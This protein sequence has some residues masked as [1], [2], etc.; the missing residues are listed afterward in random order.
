MISVHNIRTV[1]RYEA[2][3]LRRSW[4]FRLFSLGALFILTLM[5]IGMFSP[6]GN[7]AWQTLAIPSTLPQINLYMINIAQ[8]LIVIFLASDF[9]KRDKKLDTN[10]VLY[11]RPMSNLEYITGKTLGILR[12]FLGVNLLVLLICLIINII[13][14]QASIDIAAYFEYI[15][16]ISIPT[17]IFSLG[18][19]YI[20]MTLIK[21][22]AV[23]FLL[24]LGLA[25]LNM[26]YLFNR[27]NSFFDYMLFGF[28]VFKSTISGFSEPGIIVS[29]RIMY[30]S[31][32]LLFISLTILMFKRLPQSVSH[33]LISIT[34]VIVFAVISAF[35]AFYFLN[36]YFSDEKLKHEVIETNRLYQ[37]SNFLETTSADIEIEYMNKEIKAIANLSC[38]NNTGKEVEQILFSLNSGLKISN[39]DI[40]GTGTYNTDGHIITINP[41]SPLAP[42]SSIN[43]SFKY[44]GSIEEAFCYPWYTDDIKENS[45]SIGP[46]RVDRKHVIQRDEYLLL[47]PETHWYPVSGLNYYPDNPA[48]IDVDFTNYSLKVKRN[49]K[50]VAVSQGER[51]SDED[52]WY[53]MNNSPL[54]GLSLAQGKYSSDTITV[55]SIDFIAHYYEGHDYFRD[56][57]KEL[58][59][60]IGH[61]ISGIIT[62]LETN[63]NAE[64]PFGSLSLVEVPVHFNSV[65]KKNTQ[66]RAEVQ[67]SM[68]FVPEKLATMN[69]AG[70]YRTIKRQKKRME[71]SN[72]V[73][74][75]KEIQVRAFNNFVRNTFITSS[76][77]RFNRGG[78]RTQVR[79]RYLLGPSFYFYK[80]NFYSE[81]YPVINAVF[82]THLQKTETPQSGFQRMFLGGMTENDKANTIL[83]EHSM[84]DILAMNPSNDTT[85]IILSLKGDYL[86][87]LMRAE[88]GI[89]E[90]NGWFY[91]YLEQNQFSNIDINKFSRD[92][93]ERFGFDL[94]A[95]IDNWY[96]GVGQPGFLFTDISVN[97]VVV[98]NRTRYRVNFT[99]S[100]P[101]STPGIFNASFRTGGRGPGGGRGGN[102]SITMNASGR[103]SLRMGM[104]GSNMQ[105]DDPEK[106]I[107]L[108]AEQ[109]KRISIILD[110]EP[111]AMIINTLFSKNNPGELQFP[112]M[113]AMEGKTD[114]N[115]ENEEVLDKL[116]LMHESNETIVDN[117]DPGFRIYQ[118]LSSG[119]L[120]QWLNIGSE[121]GSDYREMFVWWAP[122]YWQKTIRSNYYGE[123][124]KSAV[125]TR[126]GKGERHVSWTASIDQPGYYDV[127]TYIGKRGGRMTADRGGGRNAMKDLHFTVEHDDGEEDV[128]V[129]WE[130]A[131]NGWNH[132]GSYYL[133]PDSA[134]VILTNSS[135]GR[136]V[137]GDAIKWVKQNMYN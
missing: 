116:P 87:N 28:P 47:T 23:T 97:E 63:F 5:N 54:T 4:L 65:E 120:K 20:L 109:A 88:A 21:N 41:S 3:T 129:D 79:G 123:Y 89:E 92:L 81:K 24:L 60:T 113:D 39:I 74:T 52:Y 101:E 118:E 95:H 68:I 66:T 107:M 73:I 93:K 53:F 51:S 121:Q 25:A 119:R 27:L 18:L 40:E 55:D 112:L 122:E 94:F 98:G 90:F 78:D 44:N 114:E 19:A 70:F 48:R 100:N 132:L 43:I 8:S 75:D 17:L 128:I 137:N 117:E 42:D 56:D 131:D 31:L 29:Q 22:Q 110:A 69:D 45:L 136:T 125:Y 9:L 62:E 102:V 130:N 72:Q 103:G 106:I 108:D 7:E 6:V 32:G 57:L 33:R 85:S 76:E 99:A 11:T 49:N 61:L 91:S 96:E 86:F 77:F 133:S 104:T 84:K 111:R 1:A 82:E 34:S 67:P 59:D 58:N 36:D 12:L 46:V 10:E 14:P 26:F 126:A 134:R 127:Y 64:Y 80:N 71:R 83:R 35:S 2:K 124:V 135:E 30:T 16:L 50:L 13:S 115:T 38:R 105:A 15:L 37:G